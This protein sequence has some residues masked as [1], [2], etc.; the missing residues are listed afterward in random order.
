[1]ASS[2]LLKDWSTAL[3]NAY[4]N[5]YPSFSASNINSIL[6]T[7]TLPTSP[8][9][10]TVSVGATDS[11]GKTA[12]V[13]GTTDVTDV[14]AYVKASSVD[15][16]KYD[17]V[18]YSADT[19]YAPTDSN[20]LFS[21]FSKDLENCTS[22][23]CDNFDTSNVTSMG[24][25]FYDC[26]SLTSLDLSNFDT[27]SVTS[28]GFMFY[29][30]SKLKTLNISNFTISSSVNI[31]YMFTNCSML[32]TL[33]AP[34]TISQ[35]ISLPKAMYYYSEGQI[36]GTNTLTSSQQGKRLFYTLMAYNG[37]NIREFIE[38]TTSSEITD[39]G[40][41]A[42]SAGTGKISG[43]LTTGEHSATV[44]S[45]DYIYANTENCNGRL[46][47]NGSPVSLA[48]KGYR[49]DF[50]TKLYTATS[51]TYYLNTFEDGEVWIS[52]VSDE[53]SGTRLS[54]TAQK[55]K[56]FLF[57]LH[58]AGGGG[59][60]SKWGVFNNEC[61][62]G[63]GGG[64]MFA[65]C[66]CNFDSNSV[67]TIIVGSGGSQ[68]TAG[69]AGSAGSNSYFGEAGQSTFLAFTG[70]GGKGDGGSGGSGGGAN[71][72]AGTTF[73]SSNDKAI[74][75]IT[76]TG[77]SGKAQKNTSTST[78]AVTGTKYIPE[79]G[80]FT[81]STGYTTPSRTG[82]GDASGPGGC[83][84]AGAGGGSVGDGQTGRDGEVSGGGSGG[85]N[86]ASNNLAGGTGGDGYLEIWV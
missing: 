66:H 13:S 53:R 49:P 17:V 10:P 70:S 83:G 3:T 40:V 65:Y 50:T 29:D 67:Y 14:T 38:F 7:S 41:F 24:Y 80:T 39:G 20:R 4:T 57:I 37:T 35:T 31:N 33:Y 82:S 47:V 6:F 86:K 75:L 63:G 44:P 48:K 11:T 36:A 23:T 51:G 77:A 9:L 55:R 32:E 78:S 18:F 2:Y 22:I 68:G 56:T 26:Y 54:T 74:M 81:Y 61:G 30:C 60:S 43:L 28:M 84:Y 5:A 85:G 62:G 45:S 72:S 79:G 16:S 15:T 27:S 59:G 69:G 52:S 25:M 46:M 71:G 34:K 21:A 42:T 1:M 8:D 58:G 19:I 12:Y 73:T 64:G 76:A